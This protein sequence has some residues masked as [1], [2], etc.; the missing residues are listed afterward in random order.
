MPRKGIVEPGL[1]AGERGQPGALRFWALRLLY[2]TG[3]LLVMILGSPFFLYRIATTSR[4][5]AGLGERFGAVAPRQ[6][7]RR[8]L[9]VHGVSVGE[10]KAARPLVESFARRHPEFEIVVSNTTEGGQALAA[11]LFSNLRR[12]YYPLDFSPIVRRVLRR[13]RP[14]AIVLME[15][16]VWPNFLMEAHRQRIPIFVANGRLT[17]NSLRGYRRIRALL[18][19][20]DWVDLYCIQNESFRD[21]FRALGIP[22]SRLQITGNMKFDEVVIAPKEMPPDPALQELLALHSGETVLV[23]GSTHPGEEAALLRASRSAGANRAAMCLLFAPRH[24]DRT[25]DVLADLRALGQEAFRLTQLRR[26]KRALPRAA[27]LVIDTIGEL[28]K[29][30]A[31]ADLVFVGGSLVPRGGHNVLEPAAMGKAVIVGPHTFNFASEVSLLVG[32]Q[33]ML[34]AADESGLAQAMENLLRDPQ[35]RKAMGERAVAII[36][37]QQ[38]S[39]LRTIEAVESRLFPG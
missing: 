35:A 29:F 27:A 17:E 9:W 23:G 1:E 25:D 2:D 26:E 19:Q 7:E 18:P 39:A 5:R 8:C 14:D 37:Q 28:E 16:E 12:F 6:G 24:P 13:I 20:F 31:L 30:Y 4:F 36:R 22:E 38:G 33:A 3:F 34:Q 11:R 32:G 21:R 10:T 15:L